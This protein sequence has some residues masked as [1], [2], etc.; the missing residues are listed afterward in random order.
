M[1]ESSKRQLI[2]WV[3]N[4]H[5]SKHVD[6]ITELESRLSLLIF[7]VDDASELFPVMSN[8]H[9][10][11]VL[12]DAPSLF[13]NDNADAFS[14]INAAATLAKC[15][16]SK[17]TGVASNTKCPTLG[18]IVDENTNISALKSI[19]DTAI[20]G[21]VP[22]GEKFTTDETEEAIV[23]LLAG[24]CYL[25]KKVM[26]KLMNKKQKPIGEISLTPRQSQILT[27]IQERGASNKAIARTLD[28]AESTVKLHITQ[29][30]KKFGVKNRT[31]LALFAKPQTK[32]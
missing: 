22:I 1:N 13:S 24:R 16:P 28:I 19:S 30:L 9:I 2:A 5:S 31:Q 25:P 15:G 17:N 4:R 12:F 27:L 10:A 29:V 3:S 21:V 23:E 18:I 7:P 11:L 26:N 14:I 6:I 8:Y 32:I 20:N